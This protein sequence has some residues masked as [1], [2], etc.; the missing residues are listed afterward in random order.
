VTW[1]SSADA[2]ED[3]EAFAQVRQDLPD[4]GRWILRDPKIKEWLDASDCS[5]L[6]FWLN[7]KPGAGKLHLL[8]V[9][10]VVNQ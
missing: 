1:L 2:G 9:I 10:F 4:T 7:G 3:Q 5:M 6:N 8:A